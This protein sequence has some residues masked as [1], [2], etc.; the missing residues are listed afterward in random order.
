MQDE[1]TMPSLQDICARAGWGR[2]N[3]W[4]REMGHPLEEWDPVRKRSIVIPPSEV[5]SRIVPA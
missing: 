5:R 1:A 2:R 3:V 4:R